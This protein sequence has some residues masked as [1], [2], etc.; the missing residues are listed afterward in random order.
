MWSGRGRVGAAARAL[1]QAT[2]AGSPLAEAM[3]AR[4]ELFDALE[5]AIVRAG[6]ISGTLAA[7]C[8]S[9]ARRFERETEFRRGLLAP[10]AYPA[11]LVHFAIVALPV[12]T[13][14][15]GGFGSYAWTVGGSL[16]ALYGAGIGLV[17][18]HFALEE[19]RRYGRLLRSLPMLG[20]AMRLLAYAR[21]A[22]ALAALHGAGVAFDRALPVA[23]ETLGVAAWAAEVRREA[24][25]VREGEPLGA[26]V[27]RL[28]AVPFEVAAAAEVGEASGS[29]E[30]TL[31][32]AASDLEDRGCE[33]LA[34]LS[35][36]LRVAIFL[37][38]AGWIAARVVLSWMKMYGPLGV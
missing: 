13:I 26:A 4:P 34:R 37:L 29:L 30:E 24:A 32:R 27:A 20:R 22:R 14:V 36:I 6:E 8:R 12:P 15:S 35:K 10:L 3:E 7:A 33:A 31:S 25:A 1:A 9:L 5:A 11:F 23:G 17:V 19:D 2:A 38:V 28:P 21:F 16:F 18:L